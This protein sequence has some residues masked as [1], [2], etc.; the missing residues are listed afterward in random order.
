MVM[1]TSGASLSVILPTRPAKFFKRREFGWLLAE[2]ARAR[3]DVAKL[4]TPQD[5]ADCPLVI[6]DLPPRQDDPLQI[7]AAPTNNTVPVQLRAGFDQLGQLRFLL[8][9]QAALHPRRL[10]VDQPGGAFGIEPVH[11][12]A[13]RLPVHRANLRRCRPILSLVDRRDRQQTAGRHPALPAPP[14]EPER[15]PNRLAIPTLPASPP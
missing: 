4:Q 13:Q 8:G 6:G 14:P 12:I 11:P 15:H 3:R 10:A 1:A 5:L 2:M 9:R 7:D